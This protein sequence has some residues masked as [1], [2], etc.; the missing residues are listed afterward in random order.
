MF[1]LLSQSL[2]FEIQE[3]GVFFFL[4]VVVVFQFCFE[5]HDRLTTV[6]KSVVGILQ[7]CEP[8]LGLV[9]F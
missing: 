2:G 8:A 6:S 3:C 5:K 7:G 4:L 1:H 9:S